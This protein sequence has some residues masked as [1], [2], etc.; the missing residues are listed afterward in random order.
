MSGHTV[1]GQTVAL[2]KNTAIKIQNTKKEL[3]FIQ[4][5]IANENIKQITIYKKCSKKRYFSFNFIT[6]CSVIVFVIIFVIVRVN[7]I[8]IY[9]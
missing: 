7:N 4:E 3:V 9:V 2:P 6:I 5:K 8:W 1:F